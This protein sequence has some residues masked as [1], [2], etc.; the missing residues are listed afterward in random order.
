MRDMQ[1][2][3]GNPAHFEAKLVPIGDPKL[4]VEWLKNGKPIPASNRMSTLHDFGFVAF[5][6]KYTRPDDT[7]NYT[8][9]AV[10]ELGEA[11]ITANLKVLSAKDGPQAETLHG[12][13]LS[14]IAHLESKK[15]RM[16]IYLP[17]LGCF[18]FYQTEGAVLSRKDYCVLSLK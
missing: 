12:D 9:R 7:G 18:E 11:N 5:D 8:C 10:N 13:A 3:E 6:L 16:T 15:G 2:M 17:M 14:K 1:L 4:R